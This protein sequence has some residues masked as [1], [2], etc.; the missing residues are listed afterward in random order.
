MVNIAP[1]FVLF[2]TEFESFVTDSQIWATNPMYA[3][4]YASLGEA[5]KTLSFYGEYSKKKIQI[6]KVSLVIEDV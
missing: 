6:K 3:D 2:H 4:R 5:Q 1:F